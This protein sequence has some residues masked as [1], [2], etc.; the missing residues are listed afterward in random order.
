MNYF[1]ASPRVPKV[2]LFYALDVCNHV[3]SVML[4]FWI[5]SVFGVSWHLVQ[6]G[7][8]LCL[9]CR[10]FVSFSLTKRCL[11]HMGG[12]RAVL[13]AVGSVDLCH[14]WSFWRGGKLECWV[15]QGWLSFSSLSSQPEK[16]CCW[17]RRKQASISWILK[18]FST[19][20]RMTFVVFKEW[21]YI[22]DV[23]FFL[24]LSCAFASVFCKWIWIVALL[25]IQVYMWV[26]LIVP[27]EHWF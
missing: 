14:N 21:P 6:L 16:Q 8:V 10:F 4:L 11:G 26:L 1:C 9:V 3:S 5:C 27:F 20:L 24:L 13:L 2:A 17:C 19:V 23:N 18:R 22:M 7:D 12:S 25:G 15:D